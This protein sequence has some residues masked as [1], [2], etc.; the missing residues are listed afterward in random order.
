M[1][2]D[3]YQFIKGCLGIN[4][5]SFYY[6]KDKYALEIARILCERNNE[7]KIGTLKQSRFSFLLQKEPV[8]NVISGI[9]R[10]T[11][12][13]KDLEHVHD[14]NGKGFSFTISEWGE[15]NRHRNDSYYQTSRP[16]LNLVLQLNFDDKHNRYYNQLVNPKKKRHPFAYSDHPVLTKGEYTMCWARLDISLE[17]GEV[18][19]EEIQNDWLRQAKWILASLERWERSGRDYRTYWLMEQTTLKKLKDY[20][21]WFLE[22]YLKLWDEAMLCLVLNF[23]RDELGANRLWYHTFES[24]KFLKGYDDYSLPPKSVYTKLPKRFGFTETEEAPK[25][26]SEEPYLKKKLSRKALKWF[27]MVL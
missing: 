23:C 13:S 4:K 12:T 21:T 19:V 3:E 27:T 15:Y 24:G 6:Y 2:P 20:Y 16:G 5:N 26:I 25:F 11:L 18:L 10:D 22:P 7:L 1:T 17:T 8:R 9:G 14:L